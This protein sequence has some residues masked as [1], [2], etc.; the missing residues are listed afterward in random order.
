MNNIKYQVWDQVS[1]KVWGQIQNKIHML[2][3]LEAHLRK[4]PYQT[5]PVYNQAYD[6]VHRQVN[7]QVLNQIWGQA[8]Y[9]IRNHS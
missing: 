1:I 8:W 4:V 6:K 7:D 5:H 3:P 2:T 9:Q